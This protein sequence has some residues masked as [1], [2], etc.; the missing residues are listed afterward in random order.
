LFKRKLFSL[1]FVLAAN[2]AYA[3][4]WELV[5][6]VGGFRFV[7]V[8]P[9]GL[10]DKYFVAQVLSAITA[11]EKPTA[12]LQI[13]LYDDKNYTP[14][15]VPSTDKQF[16]HWRARYNRN[17]SIGFEEFVWVTITDPKTSP[18]KWEETK[19]KIRPGLVDW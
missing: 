5:G 10:K 16:L 17:P 14:K 8:E 2:V 18:P 12:V 1:F 6:Q 15:G 4:Q 7:Y 19:A 11:K 3:Q 9:E 13:E